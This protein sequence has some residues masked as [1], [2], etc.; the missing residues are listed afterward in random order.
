MLFARVAFAELTVYIQ[1]TSRNPL[2][3]QR[4]SGLQREEFCR[5]SRIVDHG[6]FCVHL[7]F[8][9]PYRKLRLVF[10]FFFRYFCKVPPRYVVMMM[11]GKHIIL[12]YYNYNFWH[13]KDS[14]VLFGTIIPHFS[15]RI[16]PVGNQI[17]SYAWLWIMILSSLNNSNCFLCGGRIIIN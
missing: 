3:S 16:E 14:H 2:T 9:Q 7:R 10:F 17:I 11:C 15:F 13:M 5:C 8:E 1:I 12:Y 4:D 6:Q